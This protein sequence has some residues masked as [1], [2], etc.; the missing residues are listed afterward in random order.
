MTTPLK[1]TDF[2]SLGA[3]IQ[4]KKDPQEKK[5]RTLKA[6]LTGNT[7]M[8]PSPRDALPKVKVKDFKIRHAFSDLVVTTSNNPKPHLQSLLIAQSKPEFPTI[9]MLVDA[10]QA[11]KSSLNFSIA[12]LKILQS[13]GGVGRGRT[14]ATSEALSLELFHR[15]FSARLL[16]TE[17]QIQ[18][19]VNNTKIVD[20][21]CDMLG[22]RVAVSVTRAFQQN[23]GFGVEECE[24]LL[25][26]KLIGLMDATE[27]VS[28][29]CAWKKHILHVWV[30]S[31]DIARL[32]HRVFMKLIKTMGHPTTAKIQQQDSTNQQTTAQSTSNHCHPVL[33]VTIV[34]F[35]CALEFSFIFGR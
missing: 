3:S 4:Q 19:K 13:S 20:Y 10:T 31:D 18:Y 34:E 11:T 23:G 16:L 35:C 12:A 8:P 29:F 7:P 9:H 6:S 17:Q 33:V 21:V 14:A 22:H 30:P 15:L 5:P 24:E 1:H 27:H 25:K 2:P 32:C 26:R 28:E